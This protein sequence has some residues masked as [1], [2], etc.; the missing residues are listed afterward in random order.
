[1]FSNFLHRSPQLCNFKI[2]YT[3]PRT[4]FQKKNLWYQIQNFIRGY[5]KTIIQTLH[6]KFKKLSNNIFSNFL[7]RSP[8]L[9]KNP[10]TLISRTLYNLYQHSKLYAQW[11]QNF[12]STCQRLLSKILSE[13]NFKFHINKCVHS[14]LSSKYLKSLRFDIK[15]FQMIYLKLLIKSSF[16]HHLKKKLYIQNLVTLHFEFRNFE[17]TS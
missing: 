7:H 16:Q 8:H 14:N 11:V 13:E 10:K 1:M 3:K 17:D 12:I 9:Y 6:T 15:K 4:L 5:L 2:L